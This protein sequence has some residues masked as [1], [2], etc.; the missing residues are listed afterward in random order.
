MPIGALLIVMSQSQY[1]I[2][3]ERFSDDLHP[4]GKIV[5]IEAH[6]YRKRRGASR[7]PG[8]GVHCGQGGGLAVC[9]GEGGR[10]VTRWRTN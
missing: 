1:K 8:R 5:L 2:V 7:V 6:G 10:G 4:A 9:S 3:G